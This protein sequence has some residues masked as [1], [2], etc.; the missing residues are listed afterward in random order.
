MRMLVAKHPGPLARLAKTA[1]ALEVFLAL[2]ALGGGAALMLGP[3]GQII[4]LPLSALAGSPFVDYFV[5]GAILFLVIGL[6]PL[7]AAVLAR[8]RH[9]LAPLLACAAGGALLTWLAVEIAIVG[10]SNE[11]PL[12][13]FYLALGMVLVLVGLGWLRQTKSRRPEAGDFRAHAP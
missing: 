2:G 8:R 11:P 3:R 10:Y 9:R 6:G 7:A 4:P 1:I 13:A 5:P 12:Q